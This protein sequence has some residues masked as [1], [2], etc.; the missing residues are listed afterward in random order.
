M[1]RRALLVLL[2]TI[3]LGAGCSTYGSYG[4]SA[5]VMTPDLVYV[6]PGVQVVAN[7]DYPVYYAND[8][9]WMYD[10]GYWYRSPYYTGGWEYA[11]PPYVIRSIDRPT[12]YR[13]YR[14]YSPHRRIHIDRYD[15][16]RTGYYR[17]YRRDDRHRYRTP[18]RIIDRRDRYDTRNIPRSRVR[19]GAPRDHVIPR[20]H[21]VAPQPQR[22]R[23][24]DARRAPDI[25]R[26]PEARRAP[27]VR[28]AP[29][30]R[31]APDV[32]RQHD[33]PRPREHRRR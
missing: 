26:A 16:V 12:I 7:A 24:I 3:S 30:A 18:T 20:E 27:H 31:R 2:T 17:D 11:T 29:E 21:R 14:D 8:Y 5:S 10:R 25:R 6:Q 15:R 32:R 22:M 23:G 13:R 9:Y 19:E 28:R 4:V 1:Q 33:A